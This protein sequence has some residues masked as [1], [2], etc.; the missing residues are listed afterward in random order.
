MGT[1]IKNPEKA[2]LHT[3]LV[4]GRLKRLRLKANRVCA[5][6]EEDKQRFF[7]NIIQ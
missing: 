2:N 1:K 4:I 5:A 7:Y 6:E 3:V